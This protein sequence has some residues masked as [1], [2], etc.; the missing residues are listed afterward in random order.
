MF[1]RVRLTAVDGHSDVQ[2]MNLSTGGAGAGSVLA[3]MNA[4]TG[5]FPAAANGTPV[6][7]SASLTRGA[8]TQSPF[9]T[10]PLELSSFELAPA[11]FSPAFTPACAF[12]NGDTLLECSLT[13]AAGVWGAG[14]PLSI[15][16]RLSALDGT[17]GTALVSLRIN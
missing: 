9:D 12:S 8:S 4:G 10:A 1:V 13:P 7:L 3:N 17:S 15:R 6:Y 11:G 2:L 16:V 14:G 5:A